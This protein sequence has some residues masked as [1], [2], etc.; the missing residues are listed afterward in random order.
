MGTQFFWFY[1]ILLIGVFLAIAYKCARQGLAAAVL[2]VV[3]MLLAFVIALVLSGGIA[4]YI[5]DEWISKTVSEKIS[6]SPVSSEEDRIVSIAPVFDDLRKI[7]M[8]KARISDNVIS[9]AGFNLEP[10][11]AGKIT[12]DLSKIDLS[13]T[14]IKEA[15]LRFFGIDTDEND[16]EEINL[17]RISINAQELSETDLET[18]ILVRVLS[19][20]IA[21]NSG[22]VHEQLSETMEE[23]LPGFSRASQGNI[24]LVAMLLTTVIKSD[25]QTLAE[26]VNDNIVKPV[27]VVPV[28]VVV[29]SIIFAVLNIGVAIAV[30]S[31]KLINRIPVIGKINTFGGAVLGVLEATVVVF[32][33]C[34]GIRL[35]ITITGDNIIFLN[36]MTV[37]ETFIFKHIYYMEFLKF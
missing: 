8:S 16:Y 7:D 23:T 4:N 30:K 15:D 25:S 32:L 34:I 14:G 3:G 17:G 21:K 27:L 20:Q 18:I 5:Y 36:T 37:N 11:S 26:T 28:R 10:D 2:G 1:D 29:F 6:Y 19:A 24:D 9:E 33:V 12:L 13:E 31:L 35:L 22:D